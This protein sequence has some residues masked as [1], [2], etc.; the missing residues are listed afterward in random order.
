MLRALIFLPALFLLAG[1]YTSHAQT[2][3]LTAEERLAYENIRT[4]FNE[5]LDREGKLDTLVPDLL[6]S[7]FAARFVKEMKA[8]KGDGDRELVPGIEFNAK[9]L[10]TVPV[11]DWKRA[12]IASFNFT[13]LVTAPMLNQVAGQMLS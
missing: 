12:I 3:H 8:A 2:T 13:H 9:L 5:R 10:D 11:E 6:V 7:D 1:L 4:Q